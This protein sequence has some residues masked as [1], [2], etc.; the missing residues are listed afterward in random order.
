MSGGFF[1]TGNESL[2]RVNIVFTPEVFFIAPAL[3]SVGGNDRQV[4]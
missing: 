4:L 3:S 1:L 2:C